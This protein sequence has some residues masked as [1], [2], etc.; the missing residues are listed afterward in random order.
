MTV[1]ERLGQRANLLARNVATYRT[2][3]VAILADGFR[4]PFMLPA[5]D[6]LTASL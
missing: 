5:L 6:L 3:M 1:A 4:D 2:H